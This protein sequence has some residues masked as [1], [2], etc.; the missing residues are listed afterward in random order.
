MLGKLGIYLQ[1]WM[2]VLTFRG[3]CRKGKVVTFFRLRVY[4]VGSE[5][6]EAFCCNI[7]NFSLFIP[8][9]SQRMYF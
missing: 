8:K 3:G 7:E 6:V 9:P 1:G 5:M 4:M 2:L